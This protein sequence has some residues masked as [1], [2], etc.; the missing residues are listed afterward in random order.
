MA[1]WVS[2][3]EQDRDHVA[4]RW[5]E[6]GITVV[7]PRDYARARTHQQLAARA[8]ARI[9]EVE[10]KAQRVVVSGS[11]GDSISARTSVKPAAAARNERVSGC[12]GFSWVRSR[13]KTSSRP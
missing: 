10:T 13:W 2:W 1:H 8:K 6:R 5:V 3:E 12:S 9:A 7:F 11:T 4:L